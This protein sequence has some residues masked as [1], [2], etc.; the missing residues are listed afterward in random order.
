MNMASKPNARRRSKGFT[1]KKPNELIKIKQK[2]YKC[3]ESYKKK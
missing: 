2:D 3:N 1:L